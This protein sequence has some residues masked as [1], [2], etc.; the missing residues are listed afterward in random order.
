LAEKLFVSR[1][2]ISAWELGKSA[3]SIDNVVELSKMFEVPF[4]E[5]L[6]LNKK[7]SFNQGNIWEGHDR[8]F[9]IRSVINQQ[10]KVDIPEFFFQ[11]TG[12]ERIILLDAL[13]R[14]KIKYQKEK[15]LPK[16]SEEEKRFLDK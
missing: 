2:A 7:P 4:E 9:V 3:P 11:C 8:S 1:Q 6:G 5:I 12:E 15:L 16:L 10:V 13:K 14:G